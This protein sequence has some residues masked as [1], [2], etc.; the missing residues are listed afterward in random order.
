MREID[1]LEMR[2]SSA[3]ARLT[4]LRMMLVISTEMM[5]AT[6]MM[7]SIP[8]DR[9]GSTSDEGWLAVGAS[10]RLTCFGTVLTSTGTIGVTDDGQHT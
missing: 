6:D 3:V 8:A 1:I 5:G 4:G 10:V 7:V 9:R 2:A